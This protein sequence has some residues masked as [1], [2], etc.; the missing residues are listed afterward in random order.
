MFRVLTWPR[1]RVHPSS[2]TIADFAAICG[3]RSAAEHAADG[4]IDSGAGALVRAAGG[5]APGAP[6]QMPLS[7]AAELTAVELSKA[8]S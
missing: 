3:L 1:R 2:L 5:P 7:A 6:C 8:A 4:L